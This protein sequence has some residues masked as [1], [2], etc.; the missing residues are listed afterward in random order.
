MTNPGI[1]ATPPESNYLQWVVNHPEQVAAF[2]A[3]VFSLAK[4][5]IAFTQNGALTRLPVKWSSQN[6]VIELNLTTLTAA[7]V[8]AMIDTSIA[9]RPTTTAMNA[10]IAAAAPKMPSAIPDSIAA[11]STNT[12]TINAIL[13]GLRA[14][15]PSYI[16]PT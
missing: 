12:N 3:T 8:Q 16:L 14:S 2:L 10:A 11:T 7:Q 13:A 6:A 4:L 9:N 1:L 5:E 15:T